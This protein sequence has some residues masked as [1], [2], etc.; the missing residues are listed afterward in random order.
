MNKMSSLMKDN[1]IPVD[2]VNQE[3][4]DDP[5]NSKIV[6]TFEGIQLRHPDFGFDSW[7]TLYTPVGYILKADNILSHLKHKIVEE[8]SNSDNVN[9]YENHSVVSID[10]TQ[11]KLSITDNFSGATSELTYDKMLIS[12]GPWTNKLLGPGVMSPPM[13]QLPLVVSNEQTQD[14][15]ARYV[16]NVPCC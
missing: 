12:A 8:S 16:H 5:N 4:V 15:V 3:F 14:F 13:S 11:R 6:K 10:R 7:S 9:V 1:N 2:Y